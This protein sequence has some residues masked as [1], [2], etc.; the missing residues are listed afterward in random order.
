MVRALG[1]IITVSTHIQVFTFTGA[2]AT[3]LGYDAPCDAEELDVFSHDYQY[4]SARMTANIVAEGSERHRR[5]QLLDLVPFHSRMSPRVL[6]IEL[7]R[8]LDLA[9][10]QALCDL[11]HKYHAHPNELARFIVNMDQEILVPFHNTISQR[12]SRIR[13]GRRLDVEITEALCDHLH[14]HLAH[15][16][17]QARLIDN[18]AQEIFQGGPAGVAGGNDGGDGHPGA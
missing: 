9:V 2:I 16:K 5:R 13:L 1:G 6:S 8:R 12:M 11:L 7:E 17:E 10:T 4:I 15:L 18:A 14:N 3:G